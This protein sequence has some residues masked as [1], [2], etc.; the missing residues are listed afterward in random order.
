MKQ[1]LLLALSLALVAGLGLANIVLYA[2]DPACFTVCGCGVS[3]DF[4]WR[5]PCEYGTCLW[6]RCSRPDG[7]GPCYQQGSSVNDNCAAWSVC[8]AVTCKAP[9]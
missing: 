2:N 5:D 9:E 4:G 7:P 1:R 6:T 3:Q 8:E